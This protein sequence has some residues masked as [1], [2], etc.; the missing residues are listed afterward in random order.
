MGAMQQHGSY[1]RSAEHG[2]GLGPGLVSNTKDITILY[3]CS[4]L[5]DITDESGL[6]VLRTGQQQTLQN[7]DEAIHS[8]QSNKEELGKVCV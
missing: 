3:S 4:T 5:A 7:L 1:G 8:S 6:T 2:L